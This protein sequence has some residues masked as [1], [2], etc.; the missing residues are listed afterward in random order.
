MK[1]D[2]FGKQG[3]ALCQT[4][5]NKISHFIE[6]WGCAG[7]VNLRFVDLETVDGLAEG[8]F[9]DVSDVPTTIVHKSGETL[10]RWDGVIPPSEDFRKAVECCQ[11]A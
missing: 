8:A 5:K 6:K 1:V 7:K 2:V 10:A 3:C 4:T 9:F 11:Q